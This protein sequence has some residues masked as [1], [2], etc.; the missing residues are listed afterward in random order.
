M[1]TQI[2]NEMGLQFRFIKR[3]ADVET[4]AWDRLAKCGG[5]FV[6]HA[7]LQALETSGSV[8]PDT[9]WRPYH[10]LIEDGSTLVAAM[11]GYM[12]T[13]SYGEYVFDHAWANAY[14]QH[15]QDYYP[16]WV[17]AVPFTP[18]TGP[19]VLIAPECDAAPLATTLHEALDTLHSADISSVH[20][21]FP[22][23]SPCLLSAAG[24]ATRFS[25]Q[26]QWHNYDYR[27]FDDFLTALTSRKRKEIK[28]AYTQLTQQ[29]VTLERL[30]GETIKPEDRAFFYHCYQQT[31]L[32]RSGHTGY[33]TGE[34]FDKIFDSLSD[35]V[36][37]VVARQR[38]EP[39]A[40]A[41][42]FFDNTGLYG[43]YW[44]SV[45]DINGLHFIC[46]Y[47]EGIHVAIE[48]QL[49]LFNP[50]T[51]G[52]H[53]ILRGFEPVFCR[54]HHKLFDQRF[55]LAVADYL[56]REAPAVVGY[57]NQAR[58]VLPFNTHF[59]PRLKA[60]SEDATAITIDNN[61]SR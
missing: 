3:I 32:K 56:H 19:R 38:S 30:T 39:V 53:K 5:P 47:L 4:S 44:G 28:K 1:K 57:F 51:Q 46:C 9:G 41:L 21:L 27:D 29:E 22:A 6:T 49:P 45:R 60:M 40:S 7:F 58:D 23:A 50:G 55:H 2:V 54:S 31:Y 17:S 42:F 33:L 34:F 12:K 14:Y 24:Y 59:Q 48:K 10:L 37:L 18:V 16:K 43:R 36:M 8:G 13:D 20:V 26:F 61:K 11:P 35:N 15:G 52:E 25:V